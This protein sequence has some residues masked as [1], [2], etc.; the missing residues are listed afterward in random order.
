M[1]VIPSLTILLLFAICTACGNAHRSDGAAD[2]E[3]TSIE[4]VPAND[5]SSFPS[6]TGTSV[7]TDTG[8]EPATASSVAF[9]KRPDLGYRANPS[10]QDSLQRALAGIISWRNAAPKDKP[11]ER[12]TRDLY[13]LFRTL[14]VTA[15]ALDR[16]NRFTADIREEQRKFRESDKTDTEAA[17]IMNGMTG[18]YSMY[19]LLAKMKFLGREEK[20]LAIQEI[21]DATA[22]TF[23][24]EIP[25]V[26]AAAAIADACYSL[27]LM[28]ME[29]IDTENRYVEAFAQIDRQYQQGTLVAKREEDHF[30]NGIFRT[31]E[32]SQLWALALNPDRRDDVVKMNTGVS[33]ESATA[34][35]VGTQ[36][37]ISLKY[38]FLIS[39]TIAEDTVELTL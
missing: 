13:S 17:R 34:K 21:N 29:D 3:S 25:A 4:R 38:L 26:Q 7:T 16:E 20:Q 30:I 23:K 39:Y 31:F 37:A 14:T 8:G 2:R 11:M 1:R 18:V 12:L 33:D 32:I 35:N 10:L 15:R 28:I 19:A 5:T 24:P 27:T 22:A 6:G 9:L 36:M